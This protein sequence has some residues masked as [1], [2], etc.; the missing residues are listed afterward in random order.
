[1]KVSKPHSTSISGAPV[2]LPEAKRAGA[3]GFADALA[4]AAGSN[5]TS[6]PRASGPAS[7]ARTTGMSGVA[8]I[9]RALKAGKISTTTALDRVVERIVAKQTG[10]NTPAAV[11]ELIGAALRQTL[12]DDP[13]LAA[14]VRALSDR[15]PG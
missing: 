10:P 14:K 1:M 12:K 5:K 4:K 9:G 13:I 11:K 3:K 6:G 8:D 15:S 7:L 2:G